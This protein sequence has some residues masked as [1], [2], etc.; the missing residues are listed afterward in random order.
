MK[1]KKQLTNI[2]DNRM[3]L[4]MSDNSFDL[5][6]MY[7]RNFLQTDNAQKVII[8]KINLIETKSHSLY[9]QS[10]TKDKKFMAPVELSVMVT[11]S[12]GKQEY[13]GGNQGGIARDDSGNISFGVYLKELEEKKIEVDRGD[14]I[15]YNMSGEKN[16]YYEVES[17]NNVTDETNKTIGGFKSYWKRIVGVPVK[18]DVVP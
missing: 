1:K 16:R 4:F 11:I 8:H 2:E 10:K 3:G 7:G 6:V 18:E 14:I 9:G 5:D 15:E 17:A 13:Y 12:E